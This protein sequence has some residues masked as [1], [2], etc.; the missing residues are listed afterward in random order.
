[1]VDPSSISGRVGAVIRELRKER[2]WS[3]EELCLTAGADPKYLSELERGK[4]NPSVEKLEGIAGAF[5][6]TVW[7]LIQLAEDGESDDGARDD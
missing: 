1:M 6:M 5:G 2:G 3:I 7:R 4:R